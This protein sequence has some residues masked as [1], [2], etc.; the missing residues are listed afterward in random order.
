VTRTESLAKKKKK[1]TIYG[2]P[3]THTKNISMVSNDA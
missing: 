2:A 1:I 3:H